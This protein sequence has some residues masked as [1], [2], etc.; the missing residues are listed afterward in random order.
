MRKT[1]IVGAA[2]ALLIGGGAVVALADARGGDASDSKR[3][4]STMNAS[5]QMRS[6]QDAANVAS[7]GGASA[8]GTGGLAYDAAQTAPSPAQVASRV[9]NAPSRVVKTAHLE[10]SVTNNARVTKATEAAN[11]IAESNGGFVAST[12]AA[13]GEGRQ[14]TLTL[15]VPVNRYDAALTELRRLGKVTSE[16]L[17]GKDVT[18]TLVDLDARLRTLRAQEEALNALVSKARTV[19]ET[20]EVAREAANVRMQIEQLAAQQAQLSDQADFATID[21]RIVGPNVAI[22]QEPSPQP[23]LA[24]SF[25]RAVGGTLAVFGG[26]IVLVGYLLPAVLL[27][28]LGYGVWRLVRGRRVATA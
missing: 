25:E 3:V 12:D 6:T 2:A 8:A 9:P 17:G 28:A 27:A 20:L 13:K 11:H 5:A 16:T 10:L 23:L 26:A 4:E 14:T 22:E 1:Q 24:A 18:S 21:V 15:R 7:A 19:G